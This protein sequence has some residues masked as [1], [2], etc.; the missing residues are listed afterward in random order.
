MGYRQLIDAN[1][2]RAF[3]LVKDLA[4]DVTFVKKSGTSFDFG[5]G[6]V[7]HKTSLSIATKAVVIDG[8]KPSKDNNVM[9]EVIMFKSRDISP[10]NQYAT[11]IKAGLTWNIGPPIKDDGRII[12]LEIY[13]EV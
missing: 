3:N 7:E 6:E 11:I 12:V 8:S 4:V 1:L 13:K 2:T 5:A 10:V 9:K